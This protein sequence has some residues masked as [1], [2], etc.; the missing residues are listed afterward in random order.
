MWW[1]VDKGIRQGRELTCTV[2]SKTLVD[3]FTETSDYISIR[4]RKSSFCRR[5]HSLQDAFVV[6]RFF[7]ETKPFSLGARKCARDFAMRGSVWLVV[8]LAATLGAATAES[9]TLSAGVAHTCAI[10]SSDA[11]H[12]WGDDSR[13]QSSPRDDPS[14]RGCAWSRRPRGLPH[15]RRRPGRR[16]SVLGLQR[17]RR[18]WSHPRGGGRLDRRERREALHVRGRQRGPRGALLG[19]ISPA[20]ARRVVRPLGGGH[21]RRRLGVRAPPRR[22]HRALSRMEPDGPDRRPRHPPNRRL[23]RPLRRVSAHVRRRRLG[24]IPR[25]LGRRLLRRSVRVPSPGRPRTG[26]L[27]AHAPGGGPHGPPRGAMGRRRRGDATNVRRRGAA[28]TLECWGERRDYPPEATAAFGEY[29]L[30]P[31]AGTLV[32]AGACSW[33]VVAV[34][35]NHACGILAVPASRPRGDAENASDAETNAALDVAG[36]DAAAAAAVAFSPGDILC[37]G[38]GS[39]GQTRAP[40]ESDGVVLPWRAWPAVPDEWRAGSTFGDLRDPA[41]ATCDATSDARE[42]SI[43]GGGWTGAIVRVGAVMLV[44]FIAE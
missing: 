15:V 17:Q 35:K 23:R 14:I 1:W 10:D 6:S 24:Q 3:K 34:G 18:G 37:W 30:V 7:H 11:V 26:R 27:R 19:P 28:R 5:S 43:G 13:G 40:D 9:P 12:C 31:D 4:Q 41:T 2:R 42:G 38:D 36:G 44:A 29:G 8:A 22:P 16:A 39:S 21:R 20:D 32:R 25:V 33:D